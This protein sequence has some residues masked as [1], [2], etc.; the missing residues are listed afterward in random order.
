M[1]RS[2]YRHR[3]Q[4]G[5]PPVEKL[6]GALEARVMELLW[7]DDQPVTVRDVLTQL[8]AQR[9]PAIAYTTVMTVMGHLVDKGLLTRELT[10]PAYSYRVARARDEFLRQESRRI[11]DEVVADFGDAA[12]ASFLEA[13]KRVDPARL[14]T[15]RRIID[16]EKS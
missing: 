13:A 9:K 16:G 14:R 1:K 4:H 10:G 5:W 11:V 7:Q 15:L 6:L 8:N 2:D 12:I 3:R